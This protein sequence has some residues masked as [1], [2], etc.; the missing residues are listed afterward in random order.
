MV[1]T[2][3][4][5]LGHSP[6]RPKLLVVDDQVI[7]IRLV[8][9]LFKEDYDIFMAMTGEQAIAQCQSVMPDLVLLDLV[10][11]GLNGHEVCRRLKDDPRT[12]AIPIIFLSAHRDE[13]DE[14]M[15][16]ELGA[17]DY[18][19]K[20]IN[21]TILRARVRTQIALKI[22]ADFLKSIAHADGLTG[23]ANR[24]KFDEDL[25]IAWLQCARNRQPLALVILDVDYFKR[26]NDR[27]GHQQG[28]DCLREVAQAIKRTLKRPYDM[29]ARYGGEE[30]VCL[31]PNTDT[32][33]ARHL[34]GLILET[35]VAL[36]I[37]H[38]GSAVN[39]VVTVSIGAAS[40]LAAPDLSPSALLKWA[41]QQLYEA[42]R[43]GRAQVR[44][45]PPLPPPAGEAAPPDLAPVTEL[46][47]DPPAPA[48]PG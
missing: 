33:G 40:A 24:R 26:Y 12:E 22:Q 44:V 36:A 37:P 29:V 11:P 30:F 8:G 16:F 17:V 7:N 10:M 19:S 32:A 1:T 23:V 34:A 46:S 43:N 42:K 47:L 21:R 3:E 38:G 5:F 9:E 14:A 6:T 31:L 27:Y 45:M 20:P 2:F 4:T 13:I 28:D 15:G 48:L 25:E 18:I 41:D 39:A 35:V